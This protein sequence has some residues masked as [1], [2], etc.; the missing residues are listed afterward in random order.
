VEL[1]K[2]KAGERHLDVPDPQRFVHGPSG[3]VRTQYLPAG[4]AV[5][6]GRGSY[7]LIYLEMAHEGRRKTGP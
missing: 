1:A 6:S 2:V 7:S 3:I 5:E 4:N